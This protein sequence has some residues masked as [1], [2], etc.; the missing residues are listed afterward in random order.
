MLSSA[1]H[2]KP[3]KGFYKGNR[4]RLAQALKNKVNCTDNS[5][6]L[7]RGEVENYVYDDDQTYRFAQDNKFMWATG[8]NQPQAYC[9]ISVATGNCTIYTPKIEAF[10][11]Y[12]ERIMEIEEYTQEF[13]IEASK[14]LESLE[15][16]LT[17]SK[18][19]SIFILGGGVNR[20]SGKGP[21][22][23]DFEWLSKFSVNKTDLYPL[24]NELM[25]KKTSEE[26]QLMK[27]AARIGSG[28]H[29]FVMQNSR[30]G[31]NESHIQSLFRFYCKI[32][33]PNI[34]VPY[35]EICAADINAT[36]LH[37]TLNNSRIQ[38]GQMVLLDAGTKVNGYCSDIT[39][40]F[41]INGKFSEKQKQIYD[42]VLGAHNEIRGFV[43]VG[44]NWQDA[45]CHAEKVLLKG[46]LDLGLVKGDLSEL[47]A[48]R[49]SY[50]FMPHGIG[51]YIGTYTHDIPGDAE[52]EAKK[53]EIPKQNIRVFRTLEENMLLTNEPGIYFIPALLD[54]AKN[55]SSISQYFD[56]DKIA[57]YAQDVKGV[58]IEGIL[59]IHQN[60]AEELTKV[61]RTTEQ[62]E[63]CMAG[64]AWE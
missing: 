51:H 12:W 25:V 16:D 13:E 20:Y 61:P 53:S 64:Q 44:I 27:E 7:L 42:I 57:E 30:P 46:L 33:G 41:P 10:R 39:T 3:P 32:H 35:E 34:E 28:A 6:I 17:E 63:K 9:L 55:D 15:A 24:Y 4:F 14:E 21:L 31:M 5:V 19:D 56:F 59:L 29:V 23:P 62:I 38:D 43:K 45:Q 11:K 54:S 52:K 22:A 2:I 50:Y 48:K 47:W 40:T 26:I 1:T 18:P 37:Y 58:R 8:V 49:I 60:H 36:I